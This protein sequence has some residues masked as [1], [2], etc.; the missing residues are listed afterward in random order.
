MSAPIRYLLAALPGPDTEALAERLASR[1]ELVGVVHQGGDAVALG[2]SEQPDVVLLDLDLPGLT[3]LEACRELHELLPRV[4]VVMLG[5]GPHLSPLRDAFGAGA[6]GYLVHPV[7]LDE[8]DAELERVEARR[9]QRPETPPRRAPAQGIWSFLSAKSGEGRTT[10]LLAMANQLSRLGRRVVV[11]DFDLQFGD[12]G[13]LLGLE[14]GQPDVYDAIPRP[15]EVLEGTELRTR[16][17]LHECGLP[18]LTAPTMPRNLREPAD[19]EDLGR[20]VENL[21]ELYEYVLVDFPVGLPAHLIP[22]LDRSRLVFVS[23]RNLPSVIES[24]LVLKEILRSLGYGPTKL[25]VLV[26]G[27]GDDS[28][29]EALHRSL[30]GIAGVLS[31][32]SVPG[33]VEAALRAGVPPFHDDPQAPGARAFRRLVLRLIGPGSAITPPQPRGPRGVRL[34]LG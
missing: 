19:P 27:D 24:N 28:D 16:L 3:G 25:R 31:V 34:D 12:V 29:P 30:E 33:E 7:A 26:L 4:S 2:E 22:V 21:A 14:E 13:F 1:G 23:T 11:V 10:T 9:E 15:A 17:R 20:L 6:E 8:L 32:P 18:V 5:S